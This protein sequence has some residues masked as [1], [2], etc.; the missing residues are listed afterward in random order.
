VYKRRLF[1]K[2]ARQ[3]FTGNESFVYITAAWRVIYVLFLPTPT[4]Q[5]QLSWTTSAPALIHRD[6]CTRHY[7]KRLSDLLGRQPRPP[8]CNI[9]A[10]PL[11]NTNAQ[12]LM[13]SANTSLRKIMASETPDSLSPP[14]SATQSNELS[15][16]EAARKFKPSTAFYLAMTTLALLTFIV[17]LDATAL[18]V[19]LP[20]RISIY[21]PYSHF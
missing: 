10:S 12:L 2:L 19:A 15:P 3:T 1:W 6:S 8:R 16:E 18:A 13:S 14:L 4:L 11:I 17:A 9:A 20:V 5:S 21:I 7:T